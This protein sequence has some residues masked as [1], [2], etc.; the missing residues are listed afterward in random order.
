MTYLSPDADDRDFGFSDVRFLTFK[1]LVK[2]E[3]SF[4]VI[5]EG[6]SKKYYGASRVLQI[7]VELTPEEEAL[8]IRTTK[9]ARK[10]VVYFHKT[11]FDATTKHV[12]RVRTIS[13]GDRPFGFECYV[14]DIGEHWCKLI[15]PSYKQIVYVPA[16][17]IIGAD[18]NG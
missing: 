9:H 18:V 12:R 10:A 17:K 7:D 2:F 11:D 1:G 6:A 5:G 13:A 4:L 3:G 14:A 8:L 15:I 16:Q